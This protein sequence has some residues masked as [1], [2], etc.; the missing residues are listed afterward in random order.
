MDLQGRKSRNIY[1]RKRFECEPAFA[2]KNFASLSEGV[3]K[4]TFF[5]VYCSLAKPPS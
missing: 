3:C 5:A 1:N 4:L 2:A